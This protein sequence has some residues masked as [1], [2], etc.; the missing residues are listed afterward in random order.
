ML[1]IAG[2]D[3]ATAGETYV[4]RRLERVGPSAAGRAEFAGDDS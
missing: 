3:A 1:E 2:S 4:Y